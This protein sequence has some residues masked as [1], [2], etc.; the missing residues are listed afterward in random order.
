MSMMK[1]ILAIFTLV[2]TT[3][4]NCAAQ[5]TFQKSDD[6][7]MLEF[8]VNDAVFNAD[9]EL[10]RLIGD[11]YTYSRSGGFTANTL[12]KDLDWMN[13]YRAKLNSYYNRHSGTL[14]AGFYRDYD[15]PMTSFDITDM[16]V[17]EGRRLGAMNE[18]FSSMGMIVAND[19]ENTL[20]LIE[21]YNEFAR[22]LDECDTP[23]QRA[24]LKAEFQSWLKLKDLLLLAFSNMTDMYFWGGTISGPLGTAGILDIWR[25]HVD[26]Y[27]HE[28]SLLTDGDAFESVGTFVEPAVTLFNECSKLAL[29]QCDI[30]KAVFLTSED[31]PRYADIYDYT[32]NIVSHLP[33]ATNDW[34]KARDKWIDEVAA[35]ELRSTYM[36]NT[37]DVLIRHANLLS[38]V[39]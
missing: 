15:E 14:S 32:R 8:W 17:G 6:S 23:E 33:G 20:L 5:S 1:H 37:A 3:G 11:V 27:R 29:D 7:S 30:A 36:R 38:S 21:Q 31:R 26:L 4:V 12:D 39:N 35:D 13:A 22:L 10:V 9:P 18:D 34:V 25:T 28:Y 19:Y 2:L 16:V 24:A